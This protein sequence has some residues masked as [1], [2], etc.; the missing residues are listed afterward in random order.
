MQGKNQRVMKRD[1]KQSRPDKWS[2]KSRSQPER[3]EYNNEVYN[4]YSESPACSVLS[5]A[6]HAE[7]VAVVQLFVE[8]YKKQGVVPEGQWEEFMEVLKTPLPTTFR[9]NGTGKFATDLRDK[10]ESDFLSN[11]NKDPI[12]VCATALGCSQYFPWCTC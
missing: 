2:E 12:M 3:S 5:V 4:V 6:L 7:F 10:L 11:F 8:Y 9:I 1:F